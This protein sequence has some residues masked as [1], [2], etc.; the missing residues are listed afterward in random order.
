MPYYSFR[1]IF[2]PLRL[3]GIRV[4]RETGTR[5]LFVKVGAAHR[6]RLGRVRKPLTDTLNPPL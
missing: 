1:E 5:I 4:F 6:R 3:F 2:T